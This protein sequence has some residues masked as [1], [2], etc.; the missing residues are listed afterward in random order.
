MIIP[1]SFLRARSSSLVL[2]GAFGRFAILVSFA[3]TALPSLR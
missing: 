1:A 2:N 3:V